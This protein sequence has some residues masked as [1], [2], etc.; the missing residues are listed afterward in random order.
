MPSE[1][2]REIIRMGVTLTIWQRG[3]GHLVAAM[4]PGRTWTQMPGLIRPGNRGEGIGKPNEGGVN[5]G[6][7][8][9]IVASREGR[10]LRND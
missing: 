9:S 6:E 4:T 8:L 5:V 2:V 7:H 10:F 3:P 1:M